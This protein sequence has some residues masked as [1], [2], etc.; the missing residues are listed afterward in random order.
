MSET[1]THNF[2]GIPV[3]GDINSGAERTPQR[4]LEEFA[5]IL[6]AVLNEPTII[7]VGWCQYT[8]YF[9]DGELC[10][11]SASA[12]WFRTTADPDPAR[13]DYDN[14]SFDFVD[15]YDL[16]I[17]G[18]RSSLGRRPSRWNPARRDY[19][20][21]PYEGPDEAR[22]DRCRAL[23]DAVRSG[24]FDNVLLAAFGDHARVTVTRQGIT[25]EEYSHD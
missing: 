3:L 16:E 18:S 25:V 10:T 5:P 4:P 19:E 20:E 8:P 13:P 23:S 9:N 22:Y 14:D 12:I 21:G 2:L 7:S 15:Y 1:V 11:F 17:E 24:A 6:Q